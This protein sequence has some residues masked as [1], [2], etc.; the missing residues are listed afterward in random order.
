MEYEEY[1][2]KTWKDLPDETTPIK[3]DALN[4]IEQGITKA[5][6]K[7][8]EMNS[9]TTELNNKVTELSTSVLLFEADTTET[10]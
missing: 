2:P 1:Q 4:N 9:K 5:S 3:A 7:I 10:E 8:I 6:K